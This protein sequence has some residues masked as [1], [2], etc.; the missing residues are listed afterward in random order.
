MRWRAL[1]VVLALIAVVAA[2]IFAFFY[3]GDRTQFR[4]PVRKVLTQV[5]DGKADEVWR[6]SSYFFQRSMNQDAFEDMATRLDETLGRFVSITDVI[7][8]QRG[9]S[10]GGKIGEVT[11]E[12]EFERGLTEGTFG[13]HRGKDKTWRLIGMSVVIPEELRAKAEALET[14]YERIRAP[15]DV[16]RAVTDILTQIREG[17]ATEV[18]RESS[19]PF[20]DS[21][22]SERFMALN[23]TN[24][25][26]LGKFV[27]V[28]TVISSGLHPARDHAKVDVLIEFE[29]A[30]T[31]GLFRFRK[32][33]DGVWRLSFFKP[34]IPEPVISGRVP[35]ATSTPAT[36]AR[37]PDDFGAI[38]DDAAP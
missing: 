12:L 34:L 3:F 31:N 16:V 29:K 23:K 27:R 20:R 14:E 7:D 5:S 19:K 35:G 13:F 8:V 30:R 25:A 36:P 2:V 38:R 28:L 21:I 24:E 18:W 6:D 26:E 33:D 17:K 1:I 22:S 11:V 32:G 9:K 15:D 4:Q 37:L 10:L